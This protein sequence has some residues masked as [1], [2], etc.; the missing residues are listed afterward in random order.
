MT[1][2]MQVLEPRADDVRVVDDGL[3]VAASLSTPRTAVLTMAERTSAAVQ[4]GCCVD[5]TAAEPETCGV[6]IDVPWKNAQHDGRRLLASPCWL[7]TQDV[8]AGRDHVRLD[9]ELHVR[10]PSL[11]KAAMMLS[12]AGAEVVEVAAIVVGTP[13]IVL[14]HQ[15][16]LEPDHVGRD[17][18][19]VRRAVRG[20]RG[21]VAG[22]IVDDDHCNARRLPRALRIL[23][24]NVQVPREI[25]AI[26]PVRLPGASAVQAVPIP[27]TGFVAPSSTT[28]SG[29]VRSCVTVANSPDA[30]P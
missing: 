13:S 4:S 20:H 1:A 18:R 25:S 29:A 8:H 16:V 27:V 3:P 9:A 24:E 26:L 21:R 17:R 6:A 19:L 7:R 10:G 30:A 2:L 14:Q 28:S 23:V 11:E 22:D 5:T 12:F 15:A